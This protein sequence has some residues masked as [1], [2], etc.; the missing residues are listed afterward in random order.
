MDPQV[1]I[2]NSKIL[3]VLF[4]RS[5]KNKNRFIIWKLSETEFKYCEELCC[6]DPDLHA[7]LFLADLDDLRMVFRTANVSYYE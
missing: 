5:D 1:R 2:R 6:R 4:E 3:K 7:L